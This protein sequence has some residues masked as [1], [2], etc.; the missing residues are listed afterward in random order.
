M[1]IRITHSLDDLAADFRTIA[2]RAPRDMATLVRRTVKAGERA[3]V[4][5]AEAKSGPHGLNYPERITSDMTGKL[6]GEWGPNAGGT[7]VGA[8]FRHGA[9]NTDSEASAK[10]VAPKFY[11]DAH[12]LPDKWFWPA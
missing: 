11:R 10:V 5:I 7:P 6:Q 12:K 3:E 1:S 2:R 9:G 8:G 4:R